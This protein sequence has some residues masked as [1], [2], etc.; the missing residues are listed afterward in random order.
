M[1]PVAPLIPIS[2]RDTQ[3]TNIPRTGTRASPAPTASMSDSKSV[4]E[5]LGLEDDSDEVDTEWLVAR[6]A[7]P[8]ATTGS[9]RCL[10]PTGPK[11]C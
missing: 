2:R 6:G 10:Q 11:G 7:T 9:A 5:V 1:K 3:L 8:M 4:D